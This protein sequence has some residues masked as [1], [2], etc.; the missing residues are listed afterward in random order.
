MHYNQTSQLQLDSYW[1]DFVSA[2][3]LKRPIC[4]LLQCF[5]LSWT[6][7]HLWNVRALPFL[8]L[9]KKTARCVQ[10]P[11]GFILISLEMLYRCLGLIL[12]LRCAYYLCSVFLNFTVPLGCIHRF[13][14]S[15]EFFCAI[16]GISLSFLSCQK[17][18]NELDNISVRSIKKNSTI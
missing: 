7:F 14:F 5:R 13:S 2:V 12:C 6:W 4:S 8:S 11:G 18:R 10:N 9:Q 17:S 16:T 1:Q 15:S 3:T